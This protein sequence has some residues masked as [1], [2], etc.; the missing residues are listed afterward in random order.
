MAEIEV[1]IKEVKKITTTEE[2]VLQTLRTLQKKQKENPPIVVAE[3]AKQEIRFNF[4]GYS[5]T[6]TFK[7]NELLVDM[8]E[9]NQKFILHPL[10]VLDFLQALTIIHKYNKNIL[11]QLE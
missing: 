4:W 8:P 3:V 1:E 2:E 6:V 10:H 11:E 5:Y 9:E 7:D